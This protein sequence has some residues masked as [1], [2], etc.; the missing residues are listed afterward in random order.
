M[1]ALEPQ[2]ET[3]AISAKISS[4]SAPTATNANP[5]IMPATETVLSAASSEIPHSAPEAATSAAAAVSEM[6]CGAQGR[7]GRPRRAAP[8]RSLCEDFV[9]DDSGVSSSDDSQHTASSRD[10]QPGDADPEDSDCSSR[11]RKVPHK[12][13]HMPNQGHI[14]KQLIC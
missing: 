12:I 8:K 10:W 5:I 7:A 14:S 9:T 2:P 6:G 11:K 1:R 13:C 4:A 3:V